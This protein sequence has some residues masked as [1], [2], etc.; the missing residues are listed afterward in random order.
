MK[1]IMSSSVK[2]LFSW[3]L[4][5]L[6]A[7]RAHAAFTLVAFFLGALLGFAFMLT[8]SSWP[9]PTISAALVSLAFFVSRSNSRR[10]L[11]FLAF[12]VVSGAYALWSYEF[13]AFGDALAWAI[14]MRVWL[15]ISALAVGFVLTHRSQWRRA[16][17]PLILPMGLVIAACLYGWRIEETRIRCQDL[18][19][20]MQ[21]PDVHLRVPTLETECSG[22]EVTSIGRFPRHLSE[23]ADGKTYAFTTQ[24]RNPAFDVAKP[25]PGRFSGSICTIPADG[26]GAPTCIGVGSA[27]GMAESETLNRFFVANWGPVH[28][29]GSRG[30]RIYAIAREYPLKVLAERELS[31]LSGELFYD[32]KSD[33]LGVFSDE[34][35]YLHPFRASTLEPLEPLVAPVIP[36][37]THF[38]VDRR[39]GV[40]CFSAGPIKTING[41]AFGAVAF[42]SEPFRLRPLAPSSSAPWM[43]TSFSWGCDWDPQ[44]RR[45]FAALASLGV[46]HEIDYDSGAIVRTYFTGLGVRSVA[47]DEKRQYLYLGYYLSGQVKMMA[48]PSGR[49]IK[50][51]NAGRFLRTIVLSRDQRRIIVT[52]NVGILEIDLPD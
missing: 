3:L 21:Q 22:D 16:E 30:G 13:I 15:L 11:Q 20:A 4:R 32:P 12:I 48:L 33:L 5:P 37:D 25:T 31:A 6:P 34:A 42:S 46:L 2:R 23:S 10:W 36:G 26:V 50:T 27:Q 47:Y 41:G 14:P 43:W 44:K 49:I 17:I 24:L 38:D 8:D 18:R 9:V 7:H 45:V 29:G 39:E 51:W 1:K 35:E 52:S 19:T 40:L 28:E